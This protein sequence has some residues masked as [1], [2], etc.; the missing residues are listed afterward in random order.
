ML[1]EGETI[2]DYPDDQPY[3]S[4]LVLGWVKSRP[5][6]VVVARNLEDDSCYVV[7]N[8][9]RIYIIFSALDSRRIK[10]RCAGKGRSLG[11]HR[12]AEPMRIQSA[13]A[14]EHKT[15]WATA[16]APTAALARLAAE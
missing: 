4:R 12:N 1:K 6:H 7:I 13:Q 15:V 3:P 5:L 2:M 11:K 8:P 10:A 16:S 9:A 14:I